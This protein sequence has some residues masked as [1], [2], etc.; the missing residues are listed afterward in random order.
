MEMMYNSMLATHGVPPRIICWIHT[1]FPATSLSTAPWYVPKTAST[2]LNAFRSLNGHTD[3][4]TREQGLYL[5]NNSYLHGACVS[6]TVRDIVMNKCLYITNPNPME[7]VGGFTISQI[8]EA[9]IA[10]NA[11]HFVFDKEIQFIHCP[12][13]GDDYGLLGDDPMSPECGG[14]LINRALGIKA[15]RQKAPQCKFIYLFPMHTISINDHAHIMPILSIFD[16]VAFLTEWARAT[17]I[18]SLGLHWLH[19]VSKLAEIEEEVNAMGN[20]RRRIRLLKEKEQNGGEKEEGKE[21]LNDPLVPYVKPLTIEEEK[22]SLR[23]EMMRKEE[24]THLFMQRLVYHDFIKNRSSVL[25]HIVQFPM[26]DLGL[27][28]TSR[29]ELRRIIY[30]TILNTL[31]SSSSSTV[32]ETAKTRIKNE[33]RDMEINLTGYS[34][35]MWVFVNMG[36]Y[37]ATNRKWYDGTIMTI[38]LVNDIW[39][40]LLNLGEV[41]PLKFFIK[42]AR[43]T[44]DKDKD[45]DGSNAPIDWEAMFENSVPNCHHLMKLADDLVSTYS[46]VE[47]RDVLLGPLDVVKSALQHQQLPPNILSAETVFEQLFSMPPPLPLPPHDSATT[48]TTTTTTTSTSAEE[49]FTGQN[50]DVAKLVTKA[51]IPD[52]SC[53]AA[54]INEIGIRNFYMAC[55]TTLHT[56]RIEGFGIPIVESQV[57][58][59][60]IVTAGG[61]NPELVTLGRVAGFAETANF[62]YNRSMNEMWVQPSVPELAYELVEILLVQASRRGFQ[63]QRS[64]RF[65][66]LDLNRPSVLNGGTSGDAGTVRPLAST[67][68]PCVFD[69]LSARWSTADE[70]SSGMTLINPS[71][72][73][74][75]E[76]SFGRKY[77]SEMDACQYVRRKFSR[78]YIQ[79]HQLEEYHVLDR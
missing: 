68:A 67:V 48:S 41:F 76:T 11:T 27:T 42:D 74:S 10:V 77:V 19:G 35:E 26:R 63:H 23:F 62:H 66:S 53:V 73:K 28:P 20:A 52:V 21:E 75:L 44:E 18:K 57:C 34:K 24:H 78:K 51:M 1:S 56:S 5:T 72:Y 14:G 50:V 55:D 25:N 6:P 69:S 65:L 40:R 61:Y 38:T 3:K 32:Q 58:G 30:K 29:S 13:F 79:K 59:C 46:I 60:P 9:V 8:M 49:R 12:I 22:S 47:K 36:N 39:V 15:L 43:H 7:G 45:E 17:F 64:R 33:K 16:H 71:A 37:E 54:T 2:I 31:S 70:I 4:V